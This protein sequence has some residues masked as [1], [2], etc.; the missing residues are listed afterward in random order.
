M[1]K[2]Q[3]NND[4][5]PQP[6]SELTR[7]VSSLLI[8]LH[9]LCVFWAVSATV[10]TSTLQQR[11]LGIL[12]PYTRGLNFELPYARQHLTAA[13]AIDVDHRIEILPEGKAADDPANWV[14]LPDVGLRAGDRYKRYQRLG[15]TMASFSELDE[16]TS[17]MA[18]ATARNFNRR[19]SVRAAQVRCRQHTLQSIEDL[20]SG[21]AAQR[22]A[23][24]EVHFVVPYGADLQY[25]SDG[26][27]GLSKHA[28]ASE[29]A[30]P[31]ADST[32][33]DSTSTKSQENK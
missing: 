9:L 2:S 27:I 25:Y 7:S 4:D 10:I 12:E 31:G 30:R 23:Q 5:Q 15:E 26:S 11:V 22:D 33:T 14:V 29:V 1:A 18:L 20:I 8:A 24:N 13:D 19:S 16:V 32:S 17:R 3:L 28:S 6:L 21:S